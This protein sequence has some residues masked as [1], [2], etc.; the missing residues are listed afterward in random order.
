MTSTPFFLFIGTS[1]EPAVTTKL[2]ATE[3]DYRRKM[4]ESRPENWQRI[5]EILRDPD[6]AGV[7]VK[8]TA[9]TCE[10]LTNSDY[11][12]LTPELVQAIATVP[13]IVFIHE[14]VL[15]DVVAPPDPNSEN[16]G[17][18]ESGFDAPPVDNPLQIGIDYLHDPEEVDHSKSFKP[19][20]EDTRD[21]V[22]RL[23]VKHDLNLAPYKRNAH[24]A[25]LAA[26]FI[27]NADRKLLFRIYVPAG[28]LWAKEAD[29]L[30][31]LFSDWLAKTKGQV[32][33]QGGY[34]T[35]Q[36]AVYEFYSDEPSLGQNESYRKLGSLPASPQVSG[37]MARVSDKTQSEFGVVPVLRFS[38]PVY[39]RS[40][41]GGRFTCTRIP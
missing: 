2:K 40:R 1:D 33:R 25:M 15:S 18:D 31:G 21:E 30:L 12:D 39:S 34:K 8:L 41:C 10:L 27:D 32:I 14:A 3:T 38:G 19:I 28:R 6:L 23:V 4:L 16:V 29:R 17:I 24:L 37:V 20:P 7:L 11:A 9:K 26:Q 13:N 35:G 36:G 22:R 5:I